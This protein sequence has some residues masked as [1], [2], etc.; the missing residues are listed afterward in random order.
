VTA[1]AAS[2]E[3]CPLCGRAVAADME[4]CEACGNDL[5]GVG[6]RPLLSRSVL[7]WSAMGFLAVW[8]ITLAV[9]AV[10]R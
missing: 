7:W 8:L 1:S 10:V 9:V 6:Q 5:A 3:V 2:S 4:R